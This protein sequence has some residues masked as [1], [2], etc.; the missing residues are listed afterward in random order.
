MFLLHPQ[1]PPLFPT[2]AH[3]HLLSFCQLPLLFPSLHQQLP[4]DLC[5]GG[6][7][8]AEAVVLPDAGQEAPPQNAAAV[9]LTLCFRSLSSSISHNWW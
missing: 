3:W 1:K 6:G 5:A 4:P 2:V 8:A 9:L 7:E